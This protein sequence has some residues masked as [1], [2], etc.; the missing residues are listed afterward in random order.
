MT[1]SQAAGLLV[2]VITSSVSALAVLTLLTVIAISAWNTRKVNNPNMFVRSHAAAYL[3]SL[4]ICDLLQAIGSIMNAQWYVQQ[5]VSFQPFCTAQGV[6]KQISDVGTALWALTIALHT[7]WVL[8]LR[9]EVRRAVMISALVALWAAI[10][11][12]VISGPATLNIKE[13]G[14]FYAI[15]G[16]WCWISDQ[17]PISHITLDYMFMFLSAFLSFILYSLV[18]LKMRGN[19]TIVGWKLRFRLHRGSGSSGLAADTQTIAIAKQMLLYPVAYTILISP[20]AIS[21]FIGFSGREVSFG[22][23]IFSDTIYLLSGLVNVLLFFV[24]RRVLPRHSVI[25]KRFSG[26]EEPMRFSFVDDLEQPPSDSVSF[27]SGKTDE[28]HSVDTMIGSL[29]EKNDMFKRVDS[30][31][32]DT[33]TSHYADDHSSM[34]FPAPVHAEYSQYQEYPQH[35][36]H[37]Q[38]QEY[39]EHSQYP[40]YPDSYEVPHLPAVQPLNLTPKGLPASPSSARF[41]FSQVRDSATRANFPASATGPMQY[42]QSPLTRD[43]FDTS[44]PQRSA[45]LRSSFRDSTDSL[46]PVAVR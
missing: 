40:N 38:Y 24:T 25:K 37:S 39:P 17:Y 13:K 30:P 42:P 43:A 44:V 32:A 27:T 5:A 22:V 28:E 3:I 8:F 14:P 35:Q 2:L 23:T 6:I 46:S 16:Y 11:T 26:S 19:I 34:A 21:R 15:S 4:L 31:D 45:P 9:L 10:G 7:F 1:G 33:D 36:E 20:I 29:D 12:L 18:Y 41:T